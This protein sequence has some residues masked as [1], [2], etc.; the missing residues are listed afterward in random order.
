MLALIGPGRTSA[1]LHKVLVRNSSEYWHDKLLLA[2]I[3]CT[4]IENVKSIA[5]STLSDE[6][7]AFSTVKTGSG[8]DMRFVRNPIAEPELIETAAPALG[9]HTAEIMAELDLTLAGLDE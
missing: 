9:Q 3:P 8:L 1:I 5:D 7:Q 4:V 6:Y 2:S